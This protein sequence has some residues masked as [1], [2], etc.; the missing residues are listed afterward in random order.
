MGRCDGFDGA[1]WTRWT[2]HNWQYPLVAVGLYLAGV[3]A[4]QAFMAAREP[5]RLQ[6]LTA[7]W[8]FG[9][10][11][12]SWAGAAV[13][14]PH[15]L[16]NPDSGLLRE[17]FHASICSHASSYGCGWVGFFVAA[18][19]YSKFAEL[20]DTLLLLLRKAPVITLHWYHHATVLLYCW[21]SY[22]ARIGTGIWF[23]AMNYSVH[24]VMYAYF[25]LTQCGPAGKRFAKRFSMLITLMQLAQM[26]VGIAVTVASLAY[27]A[28]GQTCYVPIVNSFLGLLMYASYFVL[29]FV[30][31]CNLYLRKKDRHGEGRANGS[32][33]PPSPPKAASPADRFEG[34]AVKY[35]E[36][37]MLT[38]SASEA[39]NDVCLP[40]GDALAPKRKVA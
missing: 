28:R 15:L 14:V 2:S 31:F 20:I 39:M 36:L 17:G 8:N 34:W 23:A 21:H 19:I 7:L 40:Q 1:S 18:F 38:A 12:F 22:S 6:R 10:S 9:L 11:A 16:S 5:I 35:D 25:G 3:P 32:P 37:E 4:M 27:Q 30:L 24:A 13:V 26:V 29:F 33:V